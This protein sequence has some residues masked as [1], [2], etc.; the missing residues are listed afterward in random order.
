ML[1]IEDC[2]GTCVFSIVPGD[3]PNA[4]IRGISCSEV[5]N[6]LMEQIKALNED[7]F[8]SDL[9]SKLPVP[10]KRTKNAYG[11]NGP[12]VKY[13]WSSCVYLFLFMANM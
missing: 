4:E 1:K 10:R 6:T 7:Q 3:D 13:L 2:D 5:Y 11:L 12:Q 9:L 8:S